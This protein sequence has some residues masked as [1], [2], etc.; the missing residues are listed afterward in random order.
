M[1]TR[2][3]SQLF[4]L[5]KILSISGIEKAKTAKVGYFLNI[6]IVGIDKVPFAVYQIKLACKALVRDSDIPFASLRIAQF[7]ELMDTVAPSM[8]LQS[9]SLRKSDRSIKER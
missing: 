8:P 7:H 4:L 6:S 5:R 2:I 9:N 1:P 3:R